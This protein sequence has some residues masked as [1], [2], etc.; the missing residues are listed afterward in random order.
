VNFSGSIR[1]LTATDDVPSPF[2][3]AENG[4]N[5]DSSG[6]SC[7]FTWS[8]NKFQF[9]SKIGYTNEVKNEDENKEKWDFSIS[10]A[11]RFKYG[12]LSLKAASAD[13]P[14]KWSMTASWRMEIN[15]K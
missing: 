14:Q 5:Y 11:L 8:P 6:I 13:F 1:F 10:S 7:E 12:R 2:P 3:F 15:K 9:K 4:W